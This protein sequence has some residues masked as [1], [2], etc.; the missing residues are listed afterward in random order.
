VIQTAVP[1][2]P[3]APSLG[4]RRLIASRLAAAATVL[5]CLFHGWAVWL[6]MEGWRGLTNGQA[7]WR[8][9]HPLYFHSALVTRA[10]LAQ[11]GTTAGY[12]PSFMAGYP[13]S[14]IFPASSTLPELVVAL[15]G[16][17]R[18]EFAYKVYV[19]VSV[20]LVPWLLAVAGWL[21]RAGAGS[22][23]VAVGLYL[24]Y[25]WSDFPISYAA[26]GMVP[27]LLSIP[28]GLVATGVFQRYCE[29][30]G[31]WWWLA[32]AMLMPLVVLV[33]FTSALIVA[34]AAAALY[35]ATLLGT[36]RQ[37]GPERQW[38]PFHLGVGVI[39]VLVV[40]LNAF[41]WVPGLWL[42]G[43]KGVS[44]FAFYHP[45]GVLRRLYQIG[46]TEPPVERWL[47]AGGLAGLVTLWRKDRLG[48]V[49][50]TTFIACGFLWGYL[51]GGLRS[52]DFLQPGRHTFAFYTGLSLAAGVGVVRFLAWARAHTRQYIDVAL[53][54]VLLA[55]IG[56][57]TGPRIVERVRALVL[58]PFP[59]MASRASPYYL[60]W[61]GK[62][63]KLNGKL[64]H[65]QEP[66]LKPF[67]RESA[68]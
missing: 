58:A 28:L 30:R 37:K 67:L 45:E 52:L 14:V 6:S 35:V 34:P 27:Y 32:S 43:T 61:P 31:F 17:R 20:A 2:P 66:F 57:S 3:G 11:S 49:G 60:Q 55:G 41:W 46:M 29:M 68:Y 1:S 36:G 25:V 54:L 53:A 18:P 4:S 47:C 62:G 15:F 26:Y 5:L 50:L 42:A 38:W 13:K 23:A 39:V 22:V 24:V 64:K 19:L 63:L 33:H 65:R 21:W 44:D 51:A 59:F 9:D 40:L 8:F 12:D 16:G 48:A 56:W 10:F 7:I